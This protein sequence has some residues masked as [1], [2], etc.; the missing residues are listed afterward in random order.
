MNFELFIEILAVFERIALPF[1]AGY[2]IYYTR[3]QNLRSALRAMEGK[4]ALQIMMSNVNLSE[5]MVRAY[6][7]HE[8]NGSLEMALNRA[9]EA[10]K[11]YYDF[12]SEVAVQKIYGGKE[13]VQANA[14]ADIF[15]KT[16]GGK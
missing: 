6:L 15:M 13:D 8:L 4:L 14:A 10:R 9:K 3:R 11:E 1:V 12:L 2:A 5:A 16:H 7:K